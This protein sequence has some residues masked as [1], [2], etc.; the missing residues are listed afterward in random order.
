MILLIKT[1]DVSPEEWDAV[2]G[3]S[4]LQSV[5]TQSQQ[6]F[7]STLSKN[8][9]CIKNWQAKYVNLLKQL[10]HRNTYVV[11]VWLTVRHAWDVRPQRN[12]A[13]LSLPPKHH[14]SQHQTTR[15]ASS[16]LY[17]ALIALSLSTAHEQGNNLFHQMEWLAPWAG[18]RA[19]RDRTRSAWIS[20]M[21]RSWHKAN[22]FTNELFQDN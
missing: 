1:Q 21:K 22:A 18:T 8:L 6:Q 7:H 2:S 20:P 14:S 13:F 3:E 9:C 16:T 11:A 4:A 17:S 19:G 5:L 15:L 12:P 10:K